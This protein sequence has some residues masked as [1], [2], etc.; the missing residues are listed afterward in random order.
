[1][2]RSLRFWILVGAAFAASVPSHATTV[3]SIAE[4]PNGAASALGG[5]FQQI[6]EEGWTD[7]AAESNIQILVN[8]DGFASD[9]SITAYL[10]NQIGPG[11]TAAL[12][13]IASVTFTPVGA[14]QNAILF[15][16]L[17]LAPGSYYVT[18]TGNSSNDQG[19][20]FVNSGVDP[21]V[22]APSVSTPT[23]GLVNVIPGNSHGVAA[24]YAPASNFFSTTFEINSFGLSML[25]QTTPEPGTLL[26]MG[27]GFAGLVLGRRKLG[28][29]LK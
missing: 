17:S 6:E 5:Q 3:F 28:H 23:S 7:S 24:A 1:M 20:S 22:E 2:R 25:V 13:Q 16:G 8:V 10:T 29:S 9:A 26:L 18:L 12:N 19:W 15:S 11:T 27:L 4:P 21:I 14:F